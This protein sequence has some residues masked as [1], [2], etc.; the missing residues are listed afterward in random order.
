MRSMTGVLRPAAIAAFLLSNTFA[1]SVAAAQS[2]FAGEGELAPIGEPTQAAI[3]DSVAAVLDT[4][5]VMADV[6]ERMVNHL[7]ARWSEGAWRELTDPALFVRRLDI[8]LHEVYNDF[9]L[10]L[11]A[12]HPGD[13]GAEE[14]GQDPRDSEAFKER[15]RRTN[16]GFRKAEILP[17][18][19]GYLE[20]NGFVD[21][22]LAGD[23]GV[24]AMNFLANCDALIIDLRRNGGGSASMIQLLTGYLL[25]GQEHLV[26]WYVRDTDETKQSWSQ[27]YVPGK[28]LPDIPVY[29]LTS[30]QTGSA[31]EEFTFDLKNLERATV[32]GDTTGGGG[33]TVASYFFD[34]DGF[35][36]GMRASY[37]AAM[38]PRTGEGWEGVGIPPHIAVPEAD[39]LTTAQMDI[40]QRRR[41]AETDSTEIFSLDWTLRGLECT[42]HP[43]T[44][45][46][47]ELEPFVGTFGPRRI[48]LE[49]GVL[50][51]QREDRPRYRLEPMSEDVFRLV[52]L[53]YFRLRFG[54]GADGRV[55]R[56][57]GMYD[58]GREDENERTSG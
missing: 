12:M 7:R 37:G 23:T 44:L 42:L 33:N 57:I 45:S 53:E 52:D 19:I 55:D 40:L 6:A 24:A 27:A 3:V 29:V 54:R 10:G 51:Y 43:V 20:L 21:T 9:H 4:A 15:L 41:E 30:R 46:E 8:E 47:K 34:F 14:G 56:V 13:P 18:N 2:P 50:Y 5:Y 28:R 22:D 11:A 1:V 49:G 16:Y 32:V 26:N 17:G 39:A 38:D 58:D 48:F 25:S 36:V 31:A 35:R